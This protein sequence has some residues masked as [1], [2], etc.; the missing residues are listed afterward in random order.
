[1]AGGFFKLLL[2]MALFIV[3]VAIFPAALFVYL[4]LI[5]PLALIMI[6]FE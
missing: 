4:F 5:I 1:M 3:L 6:M 2:S